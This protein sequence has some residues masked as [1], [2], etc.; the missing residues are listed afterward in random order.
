VS[1]TPVRR[2]ADL[3]AP[4]A[5]VFLDRDGT[6]VED[7][8][9]LRDPADVVLLPGAAA[10]I[11][12]LNRAGI[13]AV[14]VTNQSGIARGLILPEEYRAVEQRIGQLLAAEGGSLDATY[15]CPH[16]PAIS[17]PCDCRKPGTL[18]YRRAAEELGLD[19]ARSWAVG[20]RLTDLE[21][22]HRLGGRGMLVRTG[23]GEAY[24]ADAVRAG[25]AVAR[26]LAHAVDQICNR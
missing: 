14:V 3:P 19:L 5:A 18:L 1:K 10:A 17:G 26:D 23:A 20:D 4:R 13:A 12:H 22:V 16:Y 11:A 24:A 9:F 15:H 6:V 25:Y 2:P 7:P 21:A 8:G